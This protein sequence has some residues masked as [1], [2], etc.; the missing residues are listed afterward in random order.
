MTNGRLLVP[1]IMIGCGVAAWLLSAD[2]KTGPRVAVVG[3]TLIVGPQ[4]VA[5]AWAVWGLRRNR[6]RSSQESLP[7]TGVQPARSAV[8]REAEHAPPS[9]M[10][11]SGVRAIGDPGEEATDNKLLVG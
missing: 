1:V 10:P 2:L 9:S 7:R 11:V 6:L 4:L 8:A 5:T 3:G